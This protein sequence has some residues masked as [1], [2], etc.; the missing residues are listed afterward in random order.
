MNLNLFRNRLVF[1]IS[2]TTDAGW[3]LIHHLQ[4]V[5][6]PPE[7]LSNLQDTHFAQLHL[8]T[9]SSRLAGMQ[10][11]P[12]KFGSQ[13]HPPFLLLN[14]LVRIQKEYIVKVFII[15][16]D[17]FW[18][19]VCYWLDTIQLLWLKNLNYSYVSIYSL[20]TDFILFVIPK[21]FSWNQC[22]SI[23]ENNLEHLKIRSK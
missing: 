5:W 2:L 22:S 3:L 15:I 23:F 14:E 1:K 8:Q 10:M 6:A 18:V 7:D 9:D 11:K 4:P 19:A 16:A 12:P 13:M 17:M 20:K 21:I